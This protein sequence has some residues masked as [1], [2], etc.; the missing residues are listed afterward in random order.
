MCRTRTERDR[1][2]LHFLQQRAVP[3]ALSMAGGY[4][5][6]LAVTV[7]VQRRTLELAYEAWQAWPGRPGLAAPRNAMD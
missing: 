4:G 3:V 1:R 6:D 5:R 7:E 2:V